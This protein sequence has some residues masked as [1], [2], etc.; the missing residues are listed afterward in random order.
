MQ[1]DEQRDL[2]ANVARERN[3]T[4][5]TCIDLQL[6]DISLDAEEWNLE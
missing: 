3:A 2:K 6:K 1:F 5:A 4:F